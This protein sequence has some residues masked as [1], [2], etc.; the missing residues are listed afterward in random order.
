MV[1][2]GMAKEG[3][4]A[5]CVSSSLLSELMSGWQTAGHPWC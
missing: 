3:F 2:I 1:S 5:V 4:L